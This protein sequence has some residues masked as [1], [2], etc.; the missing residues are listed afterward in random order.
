MQELLAAIPEDL[1]DSPSVSGAARKEL[2][3]TIAV[4]IG[5]LEKLSVAIDPVRLPTDVLDPSDP[6]WMGTLIA[7]TLLTQAR[8]P[9]KDLDRFYGS[10]VY[11]LYY[12]GDF[13]AYKPLSGA[14]TP[15]YVGKADP[16]EHGADS[17]VEQGERLSNRLRDHQRSIMA[18]R[19][20][21]IEDFDCRYLVIK[22]AWQNTA[23]QFEV[24]EFGCASS[25]KVCPSRPTVGRRL[26]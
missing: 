25:K 11:A 5:R 16:A 19:N 20:L 3:E 26:S 4:L 13:D 22:S 14:E 24:S 6:Q 2:R 1:S 15:I 17:V 12:R 10:G 8:R 18:T 23:E 21:R 7:D 9:L